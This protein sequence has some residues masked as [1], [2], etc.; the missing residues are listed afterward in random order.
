MGGAHLI[1]I[2]IHMSTVIHSIHSVWSDKDAV[3][4]L[5]VIALAVIGLVVNGVFFF[6]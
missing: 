5:V 6:R 2:G 4:D 1:S 3:E